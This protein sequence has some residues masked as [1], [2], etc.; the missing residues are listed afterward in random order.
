V[1]EFLDAD[2]TV[3]LTDADVA[4]V[5][6]TEL[7]HAAARRMLQASPA[8]T[9]RTELDVPAGFL[10]VLIGALPELD[11]LGYKAFHAVAG[12]VRYACFL[13]RLSTGQPIAIVDAAQITP[14]RTAAL[15]SVV[16]QHAL[17]AQRPLR[18]GVVG[19]GAEA[20]HGLLALSAACNVAAVSVFSPTTERRTRFATR[21]S[22]RLRIEVVAVS[23]V[24][25]AFADADA[26]YC[27]TNS[28]G[29][30]VVDL[31]E[32]GPARFIA[33]IGSTSRAQREVAATVFQQ[34]G[35]LVIDTADC[36]T[37]SGDLV[38][39]A[40][41][42]VAPILAGDFVRLDPRS[43]PDPIIYKSIGS[44]EQDLTLA[45]AAVSAAQARGLGRRQSSLSRPRQLAGAAP[46]S[47]V[48]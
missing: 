47:P 22:E 42:H 21:L 38:A 11:L 19:S 6:N 4:A 30:A 13:Y 7:A 37:V 2:E 3:V 27:A 14:L 1:T 35:A 44:V 26:I 10:R 34:A 41:Q 48:R 23:S 8:M 46:T 43:I 39:A 40:G 20:E 24:E 31:N 18:V 33:T 5:L 12:T 28:A 29:V 45:A 32:L 36:C 9:S 15:A 25:A 17:G 16:A